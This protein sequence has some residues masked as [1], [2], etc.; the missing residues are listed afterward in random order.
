MPPPARREGIEATLRD[1]VLTVVIPTDGHGSE[2]TE[3]P[4]D[5][6]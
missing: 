6:K 2:T 4:I 3:I 5:V 1:G